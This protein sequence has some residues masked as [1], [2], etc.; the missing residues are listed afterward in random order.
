MIGWMQ[1]WDTCNSYVP[2]DKWCGQMTIPREVF[3]KDGRLYQ[4]PAREIE[5]LR[6]GQTV[7][8]NQKICGEYSDDS[9]KVRCLDMLVKV[10]PLDLDE[11]GDLE[12]RFFSKD[13]AIKGSCDES[14]YGSDAY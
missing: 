9:L 6:K 1:N 7:V 8:W 12:I 4:V 2:S 10:R 14:Y 3:V 13:D 11:Y 5:K